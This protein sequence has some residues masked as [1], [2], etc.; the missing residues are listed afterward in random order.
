MNTIFEIASVDY[1]ETRLLVMV[2]IRVTVF[3][4]ASLLILRSNIL[5]SSTPPCKRIHLLPWADQHADD[6]GNFSVDASRVTW[7]RELDLGR[8][9]SNIPSKTPSAGNPTH[10]L[11]LE[12]ATEQLDL[13]TAEAVDFDTDLSEY[14]LYSLFPHPAQGPSETPRYVTMLS[15]R[16]VDVPRSLVLDMYTESWSALDGL[17]AIVPPGGSIGVEFDTASLVSALAVFP[18]SRGHKFVRGYLDWGPTFALNAVSKTF[19]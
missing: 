8:F 18:S 9:G 13:V 11:G 1:V 12:L 6:F 2:W 10:F 3:F 17:I 5:P 19:G 7:M 15:S 4:S 14:Q 16:N